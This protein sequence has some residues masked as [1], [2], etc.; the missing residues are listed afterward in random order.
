MKPAGKLSL[1]FVSYFIIFYLLIILGFIISLV[2]FGLFINE[3]V[4]DNIHTMSSFEIEDNAIVKNGKSVKIADFL[5]KRAEENVGQL[6][7]LN[8]AMEIVDYTGDSCELCSMTDREMMALKRPGMHTW[9]I[10]KY[11]LLFLPTSPLQPMFNEVLQVIREKKE[12]PSELLERLQ[13]NQIAIEIYNERWNRVKVIGEHYK[14]LHKPQLLDEK[15]DIFEQAELRQSTSLEDGSTLIVRMPNPSY[16]PFEEPFNKAMI[17]FVSIFFGGHSILLLGIILLSMSISRQFVRPLVY[18]IS[19]IERLTQF[20]YREVSDNKIHHQKT[21][22]LKRKF[23]LFQPVDES[24]NHLSERLASNERQIQ[25]SEQLREEWITGLSHDLKTPLSSIYGYSTMLASEEYEWTKEEMRIFANTM[26][27][28]ANYMDLL[29]QDLTYSYQ[30]KNKA[31]QLEK[32]SLALATWLPQ[33]ADEQVSIKVYGDVML[34]ADE[35]LLKR[36][37]DNLITNAK[38][39]TPEGT[40]VL[41]EAQNIDKGIK[42]TIT[43]QGPGIPQDELDNLFERYYRGTN[44]TDDAT[45]TGLGLAI[46]KQLIDLHNGTICVHSDNNGTIFELKFLEKLPL[47]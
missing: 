42:L 28:K 18:V 20:D 32:V 37:L 10:P 34:E 43:D 26:R 14:K 44:T 41:V 35:L 31:I 38:K 33:F 24:L 2:V 4:G 19:R 11:Y 39:Y 25:Q 6:Y 21:G 16:K 1:R 8:N 15:Y 3:R 12:F 30:L 22:K 13:A 45:G 27:E 36:I 23:K 5:E 29:I 40:K 46:T 47:C 9:E 7:L 17:L